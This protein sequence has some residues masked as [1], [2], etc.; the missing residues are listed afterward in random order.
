MNEFEYIENC[1]KIGGTATWHKGV[2]TYVLPRA[3]QELE[4]MS[5]D[6]LD[7]LK[8]FWVS[9]SPDKHIFSI[10]PQAVGFL[11]VSDHC[12]VYG[13]T[14]QRIHVSKNKYDWVSESPNKNFIRGRSVHSND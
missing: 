13:I 10:D 12:K 1:L 7:V 5:L 8:D 6:A 9:S 14:R 11:K 4:M 3:S 2:L